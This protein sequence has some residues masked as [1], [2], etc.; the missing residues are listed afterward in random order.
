MTGI[1]LHIVAFAVPYPPTYG[2]AMDVWNRVKA[3]HEAGVRIRLHCFVYGQ[4]IPQDIITEM[5][6]EVHYY[7][8][9]VWPVFFKKGQPFVIT[10]RKSN[11]LLKRLQDDNI[12]IL[13][14][15]MQTTGWMEFLSDRKKFLRAH[16]VEHKYYHQLAQNSGGFRSMIYTRESQ[17]LEDYER[18]HAAGFDAIFTIAEPDQQW[19]AQQGGHAVLLPP[20]HGF[21][22]VD[23]DP[24]QGKYL[25]YQGDL[26]IEINQRA[27]LELA[28]MIPVGFKLTLVIAG[29]S[30]DPAFES[31]LSSF[32]NIRREADVSQEKMSEL[33]RH[34]HILLVHS[35]HGE[36]MKMKLFPALFGGRFIMANRLSETQSILDQAIHF[37]EPSTFVPVLEA[38]T[39]TYFTTAE[40]DARK[41][42]LNQFPD[43]PTKARQI[44]RYL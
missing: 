25:L 21:K 5:V 4:Y 43:D 41:A 6:G 8:R 32:V 22:Q 17:C 35:L 44:I 37:Y 11:Q 12:P 26:S 34:A 36:G 42:I 40:L 28:R 2:G 27:V 24:G 38:L 31:K 19:F 20:F 3:L 13:F 14:E 18:Q 23:I 1:D 10:S 7:A 39:T 15:G 29:R 30:G 33:I 16:N 9:S